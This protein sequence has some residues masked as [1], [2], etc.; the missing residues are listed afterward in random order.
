[1]VVELV[2][3][4][5]EKYNNKKM[6]TKTTKASVKPEKSED[7]GNKSI[8]QAIIDRIDEFLRQKGDKKNALTKA[9]GVSSGYFTSARCMGAGLGVD[10]IVR[11]LQLYPELSPDWLLFGTGL[12]IRNASLH[13][14]GPLMEQQKKIKEVQQDFERL[15]EHLTRLQEKVNAIK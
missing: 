5:V 13:N 7:N 2:A 15:K 11:I 9:I 10:K 8:S 6:K 4:V 3:A 14:I 12:M 1:M